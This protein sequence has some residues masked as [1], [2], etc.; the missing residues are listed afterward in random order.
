M[1]RFN[2]A[3][4]IHRLRLAQIEAL[5]TAVER[6]LREISQLQ[7][8]LVNTP[9]FLG[10]LKHQLAVTYVTICNYEHSLSDEQN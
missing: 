5:K 2:Q 4:H 9:E 7:F 3:T 8:L 1:P 6:A 10:A